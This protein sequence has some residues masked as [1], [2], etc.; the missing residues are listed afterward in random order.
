MSSA[1]CAI[2]FWA[3]TEHLY[4]KEPGNPLVAGPCLTSPLIGQCLAII[5]S[6]KFAFRHQIRF[7]EQFDLVHARTTALGTV[8]VKQ[9][10]RLQSQERVRIG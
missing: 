5:G 7:D 1:K 10:E 4:G 9:I 6:D 3:W 8:N 2:S